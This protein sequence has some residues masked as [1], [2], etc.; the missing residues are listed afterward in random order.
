MRIYYFMVLI[1]LITSCNQDN[2]HRSFYY[3]KS[4]YCLSDKENQY[5]HDL[6]ISRLYIRFFD[7]DWDEN[8]KEAVPV[9]KIRFN[10]PILHSC[11][12]IPVVYIVNKVLVNINPSNIE[13]LANRI[14]K[15]VE[16]ICK[17]NKIQFS[18]LQ[19]DCDWTE[20]TQ[21]KY[22]NLLKII[23]SNLKNENKL[24]SAT[25][26]LH[27]VKYKNFTGIPPVDRGMLMYYNMGKISD[28]PDGNSVYNAEDAAKYISS[29]DEYPLPLDVAL[30][31]YSWGIHIR[32]NH[33]MEL[34]N[35][36]NNKDFNQNTEF[37]QIDP[38]RH[39]AEKSFYFHGY[40][41]MKDDIV[42]V[43]EI[44]PDVCYSAARQLQNKLKKKIQSVAIF[45]L[46][47][48]IL[49]TYE[50]KDFEKVFDTFN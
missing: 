31:A 16:H 12:V 36:I 33:V 43:E 29:L 27:Q 26:R 8:I 21:A 14:Y 17:E 13:E 11:K 37:M 23:K 19:I 40:Y 42:K 38:Y 32:E 7:I 45:H 41:F 39:K 48:L 4:I 47:S 9:A 20:T 35:G 15:Q 28:A 50:E 25:I 3:W 18:E 2:I 10:E 44:T 22:F 49:T 1:F 34:L 6:G 24:L 5:I 46:D 30:P